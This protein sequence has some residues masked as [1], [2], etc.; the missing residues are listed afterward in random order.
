MANDYCV[1]NQDKDLGLASISMDAL[2]NIASIVLNR[3]NGIAPAKKEADMCDT[4]VKDNEI[5]VD[6]Y[7]KINQ[8]I[9]VVKTCAEIQNEVYSTILDILGI[10]CKAIN[11]N[12]SGFIYDKE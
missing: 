6:L 9:D 5:V 12:I 4:K 1:I 2:N 7:I 11:V 10:K 3:I 8:G